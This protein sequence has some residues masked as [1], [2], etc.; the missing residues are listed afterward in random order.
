MAVVEGWA[1]KRQ[2]RVGRRP[3]AQ[4]RL[5]REEA[6]PVDTVARLCASGALQPYNQLVERAPGEAVLRVGLYGCSAWFE[7]DFL[8]C[9][10]ILG[11]VCIESH[12]GAPSSSSCAL[13]TA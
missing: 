10:G 13:C 7:V 4:S 3:F 11:V 8:R 6:C 1:P 5:R 9:R 12:L 2:R